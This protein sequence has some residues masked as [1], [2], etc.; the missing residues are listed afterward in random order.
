[1]LRR[2]GSS[3]A[4]TSSVMLIAV[5]ALTPLLGP[6]G[7]A[8]SGPGD[9]GG[10]DAEESVFGKVTPATAAGRVSPDVGGVGLVVK[11]A[12]RSEPD[13]VTGTTFET[14][15]SNVGTQLLFV[16][17][18]AGETR[19]L[20]LSLP[21]A[22]V[23]ARQALVVDAESTALG[24][25]F[26]SPG[27]AA[28]DP[29]LAADRI[30]ELKTYPAFVDLVAYLREN[31]PVDSLEDLLAEGTDPLTEL[32]ND[33]AMEWVANHPPVSAAEA[34]ARDLREGQFVEPFGE[35]GGVTGAC[36]E[37]EDTWPTVQ[38]RLSNSGWRFVDVRRRDVGGGWHDVAV[39]WQGA[40]GLSFG[41]VYTGTITTP[42]T[43]DDE[44]DFEGLARSEYFIRGPGFARSDTVVPLDIPGDPL[45]PWM[46]TCLIYVIMPAICVIGGVGEVTKAAAAEIKTL[47]EGLV[48]IIGASE[49]VA[50]AAL[51]ATSLAGS[52]DRLAQQKAIADLSAAILLVLIGTGAFASIVSFLGLSAA[53]APEAAVFAAVVAGAAGLMGLGNLAVTVASLIGNPPDGKLTVRERPVKL[54]VAGPAGTVMPGEEASVT[55]TIRAYAPDQD[56]AS[57]AEP[58]GDFVQGVQLIFRADDGAFV[59]GEGEGERTY[60]A[61][62]NAQGKA[63]ALLTHEEQATVS[64]TVKDS[65]D[66]LFVIDETK[67]SFGNPD[68]VARVA[69]G[70]YILG[71]VTA[72]PVTIRYGAVASVEWDRLPTDLTTG[73]RLV[74]HTGGADVPNPRGWKDGDVIILSAAQLDNWL[75]E[76]MTG[77]NYSRTGYVLEEDTT[78]TDPENTWPDLHNKY[79]AIA[80]AWIAKYETWRFDVYGLTEPPEEP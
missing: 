44:I 15:V 35:T 8:S 37:K 63:I 77:T 52:E 75:T 57:G 46:G 66:P 47:T 62:T 32:V 41:S 60:H 51:A 6:L 14:S 17:D 74:L 9:N 1:M 7:C 22:Q 55:A 69:A 50:E 3:F 73:A 79:Q 71:Q 45:A 42:S 56:P 53:L 61:I 29:D 21:E 23:T 58:A 67:V 65:G 72:D 18:Q 76:M 40:S 33:V 24:L 54:T 16:S 64:V 30:A 11:S 38:T 49:S 39:F 34:A 31:L 59:G 70:V 26:L 27:I 80:D 5:L 19:G 20:A 13:P 78:V 12:L 2:H 68:A 36:L 28:P 4:A 43:L 25:L 48:P 10:D